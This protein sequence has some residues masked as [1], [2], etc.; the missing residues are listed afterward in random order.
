MGANPNLS[1]PMAA[2]L[3]IKI[4]S[5]MRHLLYFVLLLASATFC[6]GQVTTA[7]TV[8]P[9]KK[10]EFRAI[11]EIGFLGAFDH[12][13]QFGKNG[14]YFDYVGQGGQS[15]LYPNTRLSLELN[16]GKKR[17]N[18]LILLYQPLEINTQVVLRD[19]IQVDDVL[20]PAGTNLNTQYSF[21]F[22]RLSYLGRIV[23]AGPFELAI[24]GSLQIRNAI[25]KF[26]SS[27]GNLLKI[28]RNVGFVPILK[29]RT[30]YHFSKSLY[31]E[32]EVD[33][34]YAPISYLNGND[35]DVIGAI[36]DASLRQ[37]IRLT[38]NARAFVNFRYLGG[39]AEGTSDEPSEISDGYTK[40]WLHFFAIT[41]GF[42]Y[43]F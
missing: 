31:L 25:I 11:A 4:I 5:T 13:I 39:G 38:N 1:A 20:F 12:R 36:I 43:S 40:N 10:Y 30:Q 35:N 28:T 32:L 16:F 24:G 23:K 22:Y 34:F 19:D 26:E 9:Q 42:A 14:T 27:D 41:G 2:L 17:K 33:G 29:F 37:N 15:T 6:Q 8:A 3:F 7:E 21:P 18:T